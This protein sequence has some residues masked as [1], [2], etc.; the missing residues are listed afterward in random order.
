MH[1]CS[2]GHFVWTGRTDLVELGHP[3][4]ATRIL[5]HRSPTAEEFIAL[6]PDFG[7]RGGRGGAEAQ[8][9]EK[10]LVGKRALE[11]R[12]GILDQGVEDGQGA[13]LSMNITILQ[14]LPEGAGSLG[15]PGVLDVNHVDEFWKSTQ[16]I[17]GD[18]GVGHLVDHYG[19][20]RIG[21]FL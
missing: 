10:G 13:K 14:L 18:T 17:L 6:L 5:I 7:V 2:L 12:A 8:P 3:L 1:G 16:I 9:L 21:A 20:G 11:L 19:H 4:H 15:G